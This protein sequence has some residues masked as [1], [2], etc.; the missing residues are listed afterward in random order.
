MKI[1]EVRIIE[2]QNRPVLKIKKTPLETA[3]N[4]ATL[5]LFIGSILYLLMEWSSLPNRVPMHYNFFG[6]IDKWG[7]KGIIVLHP[8]IGAVLWIS[9]TVLEKFPHVYNYI[10]LTEKNIEQ[11][12]KNVR[13]M[14]N[15]IKNE[16]LI[17]ISYSIWKDIKAAYG[18]DITFGTW[19][20]PLFLIVLFS[21]ISFF[22]VRSIR[23]R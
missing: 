14:I 13:I 5:L 7:S 19:D 16:I 23:L 8:I 21:S 22:I 12:Y 4:I 1:Q 11:Q 3:L 9:L 6:E 15:V 10:N 20:L 2:V 18:H 17:Y